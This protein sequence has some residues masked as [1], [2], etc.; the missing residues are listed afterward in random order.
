MS[1]V[2]KVFVILSI[3]FLLTIIGIFSYRFIYFYK[4]N[5]NLVEVEK[6]IYDLVLAKK[7]SSN[8]YKIDNSYFYRGKDVDN[9]VVYSGITWR[10]IKLENNTLTLISNVPITNLYFNDSYEN[11]KINNYLNE[12]FYNVLDNQLIIDTTTCINS[13]DINTCEKE[14]KNKIVLLSFDIYNKIG[15]INSFVNN[16]YYMYLSNQNE[17]NYYINDVGEIEKTNLNNLYGIK[18]VITINSKDIY[19][20]D[21]SINNP[22]LLDKP[23]TNLKDALVG[24]YIVFSDKV[25]RIVSKNEDSVKIILN[26][27]VN[28]K[29]DGNQYNSNSSVYNYLN[30]EFYNSLDKELIIN[31]KWNNGFFD[32]NLENIIKNTIECKI[33]FANFNDL[34]INDITNH[35][36]MSTSYLGEVNYYIKNNSTVYKDILNEYKVRPM[37]SL[38]NDINVTGIGT[39][40]SPYIIGDVV[41]ESNN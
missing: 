26:D 35:A 21:G 7:A 40:T 33:G 32:G 30:N 41:N 18:P 8:L 24:N 3:I 19:S 13:K 31:T 22:Y 5:N 29:L 38:K 15:G 12:D 9:Y 37:L 27:I 6:N 23:E 10:I 36:L 4:L 1:K 16:G 20:G 34:F 14:Y 17:E 2:E 28:V 11:S 39:L 25:F